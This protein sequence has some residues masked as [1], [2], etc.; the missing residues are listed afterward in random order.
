MITIN[1]ENP[2]S[3]DSIEFV[4][5]GVASCYGVTTT[6][7]GEHFIFKLV[8]SDSPLPCLSAPLPYEM[9][10]PVGRLIAGEYQVT[11][12]DMGVEMASESFSVSEGLLPFP[13]PAIPTIGLAGAIILA[14]G[15]AWIANKAFNKD[16]AKPHW[17]I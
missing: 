6:V 11:H 16:A 8:P 7:E 2:S 17:L 14:I 13:A 15:L 3:D 5:T 12:I 1:P 4:F 9:E 10:W